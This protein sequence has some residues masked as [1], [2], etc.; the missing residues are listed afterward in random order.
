VVVYVDSIDERLLE[1][2]DDEELRIDAV[3]RL[4]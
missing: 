3:R 1:Y 2:V 4:R